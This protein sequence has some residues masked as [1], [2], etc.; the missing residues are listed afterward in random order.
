MDAKEQLQSLNLSKDIESIAVRVFALL[1]I[2]R[3]VGHLPEYDGERASIFASEK[4]LWFAGG[5]SKGSDPGRYRIELR[6]LREEVSIGLYFEDR[7]GYV[8]LKYS[9]GRWFCYAQ[10]NDAS[11]R[12]IGFLKN[13]SM[14]CR[15][16]DLDPVEAICAETEA[17][18]PIVFDIIGSAI[19]QMK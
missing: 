6:V 18:S 12:F 17:L 5:D 16:R 15:S 11:R 1:W 7:Q 10:E 13:W 8:C 14:V 2:N 19:P 4:C 3:I 9:D